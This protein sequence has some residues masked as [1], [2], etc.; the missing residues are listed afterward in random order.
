MSG[1]PLM[2]RNVSFNLQPE[3]NFYKKRDAHPEPQQVEE[4]RPVLAPLQG[5]PPSTN[6]FEIAPLTGDL[7]LQ[8]PPPPSPLRPPPLNLSLF[9]QPSSPSLHSMPPVGKISPLVQAE[10]RS[11]RE[12]EAAI[13]ADAIAAAYQQFTSTATPDEH[14]TPA[15]VASLTRQHV[16][17]L[18]LSPVASPKGQQTPRT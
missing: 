8:L 14:M 18:T 10:I 2:R 4:R 3:V 5:H 6:T 7:S 16:S 1:T 15:S 11:A 9:C 17:P 13:R 12:H